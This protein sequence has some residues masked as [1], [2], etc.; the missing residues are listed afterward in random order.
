M[1]QNCRTCAALRED[2]VQFLA[3]INKMRSLNIKL[4]SW[5][6]R[7]G[8]RSIGERKAVPISH[9]LSA[10]LF[11][12]S[13]TCGLDALPQSQVKLRQYD[14]AFPGHARHE[15]VGGTNPILTQFPEASALPVIRAQS[16]SWLQCV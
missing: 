13:M 2:A 16:E 12:Q 6:A 5:T 7:A 11:S 8:N 15:I 10:L 9:A 3:V 1:L 4:S 14:R